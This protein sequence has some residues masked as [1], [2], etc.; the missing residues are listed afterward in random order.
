MT[1]R[2][3]PNGCEGDRVRRSSR[4]WEDERERVRSRGGSGSIG[5]EG[6]E[7]GRWRRK[8]NEEERIERR[9]SG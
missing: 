8:E 7:V 9:E 6:D 4:A 2:R 5:R 1:R 3:G